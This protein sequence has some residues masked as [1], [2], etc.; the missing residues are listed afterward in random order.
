ME[1]RQYHLKIGDRKYLL[2]GSD[3]AGFRLA[4][5][6]AEHKDNDDMAPMFRNAKRPAGKVL[7]TLVFDGATNFWHAH[8][9]QHAAKNFIKTPCI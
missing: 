7:G 3:S 6:I 1:N 5:L 2:V 8:K 4:K 9:T